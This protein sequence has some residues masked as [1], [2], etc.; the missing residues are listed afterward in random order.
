MEYWP[1][2]FQEIFIEGS[3][4]PWEQETEIS[5]NEHCPVGGTAMQMK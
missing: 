5:L 3:W 1:Y 4:V 2:S